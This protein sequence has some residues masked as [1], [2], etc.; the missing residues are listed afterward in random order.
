ME[1][2]KIDWL[3]VAASKKTKKFSVFFQK[4]VMVAVLWQPLSLQAQTERI[5]GIPHQASV[6]VLVHNLDLNKEVFSRSPQRSL[7]SASLMKLITTAAAVEILGPDFRFNTNFLISGRVENGTLY[8]NLIVEGGG[9]PTFG[10]KYFSGMEPEAVLQKVRSILS[11]AG[12]NHITGKILIDE[13]WLDGPR[14]PSRRLW[15][16]MGNYYGAP[17]SALTWR[18]NTFRLTMKS[19]PAVGRIC[20]VVSIVPDIPKVNFDCR[21]HSASHNKDS[22]YIYGVPGMKEWNIQGSIPAGRSSFSIKGALPE[23]GLF[24]AEE[25]ASFISVSND[26]S[27]ETIKDSVL[28]KKATVIG[29]I[30]SPPL[31]EIIRACNRKSINLIA[32][33]LLLAIGQTLDDA[34]ESEWD[35]GFRVI[36][37]F[38]D[39]KT[40]DEPLKISDGSGLAPLSTFSAK[41]MVAVLRYMYHESP[42]FDLFK[43]SLAQSGTSGTLKY[44]WLRNGLAG[45]I[46]GKSASMDDVTNYAG[47]VFREGKDPLAF[48]FMVNHHGLEFK[49]IRSVIESQIEEIIIDP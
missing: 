15:E 19:P 14:F 35:R 34:T 3:L 39:D 16:D 4:V 41:G 17:P 30:Q 13:S 46:F 2:K 9:D 36:R 1:W 21:V 44:M 43:Q 22:A 42:H 49:E 31:S 6:S 37:R 5:S 8:G 47:Y 48:A 32:D 45:Q 12:I 38:W 27:I 11:E 29:K 7:I 33:H 40:D 20:E 23:P 18:D 28:L 26:F 25:I 24:F 10:S